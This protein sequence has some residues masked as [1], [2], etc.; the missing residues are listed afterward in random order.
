MSG[1]LGPIEASMVEDHAHADALLGRALGVRPV[2]EVAF[3]AFRR[4]LLRHMAL[5]E[6]VLLR[7]AEARSEYAL[8]ERIRH[9]HGEIRRL[10]AGPAHVDKIASLVE[11]L[12]RHNGIEEGPEGLYAT[13]DA[14]AGADAESLVVRLKRYARSTSLKP[15]AGI[16]R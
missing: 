1:N 4:H 15:R 3:A 7:Y 6:D 16:A 9:D 5:E 10:L 13:C 2:D 11:L 8:G 14:I 12:G